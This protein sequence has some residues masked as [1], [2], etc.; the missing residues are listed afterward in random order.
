[1]TAFAVHGQR[2]EATELLDGLIAE[3]AAKGDPELAMQLDGLVAGVSHLNGTPARVVRARLGRYSGLRGDTLGE[4]L[5]L[6]A[7]AFEAC[8]RTAPA[9]PRSS[10]RSVR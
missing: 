1:M 10:W 8:H 2:N 9:V 3:I 6:S 7:M 5:L 4:Q